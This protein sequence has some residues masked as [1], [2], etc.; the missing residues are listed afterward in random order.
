[1]KDTEYSLIEEM[2]PI[3]VAGNDGNF[4]PEETEKASKFMEFIDHLPGGFLIYRADK[5][6]EIIYANLALIHMFECEDSKE[7]KNFTGNSFKGIVY[8]EDYE[9]VV[10]SIDHQ[11]SSDS[12]NLD[13]V[14]YRILTKNGNIRHVEDYGHF[15]RTNVGD[16]FYVFISDATD[17]ITQRQQERLERLEVI[18]GLSVDYESILYVD[19][20]TDS[21]IPYRT[22]K[23]LTKQ[24]DGKLQ[25]KSYSRVAEDFVNSWVH[26][27]DRE[28]IREAL[29]TEYIRKMLKNDRTY[30]VNFICVF[31]DEIQ[32]MQLRIVDVKNDGKVRQVVIG[33]RNIEEEIKQEMQQKT[34]LENALKDAKLADVAKDSFLSN[35]SHDMRTPL[36]AI[37][38]YL[39]L[40]KKNMSDRAALEKYLSNVG[41]AGRQL[42]DL[43]DKVLEISYIESKD[44]QL[45]DELC[46][47][48]D[49]SSEIYAEFLPA[50]QK[51]NIAF[52][53]ELCDMAH[54][55]VYTDRE[56][57]KQILSNLV[58]NAVK[59]TNGGGKINFVIEEC[60]SSSSDF[61][62]YRF[63]VQDTGI[64]IAKKS[65]EKIF[66]PFERENNS[67]HSGVFG[68]GL[69]LTI[70]KQIIEGMGGTI[71]AESQ[72][73][74][75]STFTVN[76]SFKISEKIET[77]SGTDDVE[78]FINGKKILVVEDNEINLEIET[79]LLEDLGLKVD[80]AE[81]GQ[82]AVDIMKNAKP[83]EYLF[84]L[85]DIQM[86]VMDGW[87]ATEGIRNLDN[88]EIANI[89]I[90]ALSANAFDSDKRLSAKN[91]M[92][93]HLNKPIDIPALLNAVRKTV[94]NK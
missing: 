13:Y 42:L 39:E 25:A 23:R 85:M 29:S 63:V 62:A 9:N 59:Y 52:T 17:K 45:K 56:Q 21:V 79:E 7:F 69:G 33:S 70:A 40:A 91:G 28:R 10:N 16:I 66:E 41:D 75:G 77:A 60:P 31:G 47:L 71:T 20:D 44:F 30:Y 34:L 90:I 38:G 67:T 81:N 49:V 1:M 37:F 3:F 54:P 64:G 50:A 46:N 48:K 94:M 83:H 4:P 73:G 82:I 87:Q 78:R 12:K 68:S 24:F 65:L 14:E 58:S 92:N 6:E 72:V 36:N 61:T 93:A 86:P 15:V 84:V 57:F 18:E 80:S 35:I 55:E 8:H 32:Y 74:V 11:I 27:D 2:L 5:N 51:K 89:P 43:V 76:L 88:P 53:L 26:P 22:S 19:L